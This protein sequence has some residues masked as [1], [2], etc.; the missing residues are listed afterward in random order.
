MTTIEVTGDELVVHVQGWDQLWS[1][2]SELRIPLTHVA[3]AE[4][5]ECAAHAWPGLRVPGTSFPGF[6]AGTYYAGDGRAFWDVHAPGKAIEI[7]LRDDH[8]AKLVIDV[9]DPDATIAQITRAVA[10]FSAPPTT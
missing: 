5:S 3:R 2:K 9:E 4:R 1:F 6:I 10:G 7:S 8:F